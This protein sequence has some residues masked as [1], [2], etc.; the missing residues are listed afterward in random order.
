MGQNECSDVVRMT[1]HLIGRFTWRIFANQL[2][3][4]IIFFYKD[5]LETVFSENEFWIR[6]ECCCFCFVFRKGLDPVVLNIPQLLNVP[7]AQWSNAADF[8]LL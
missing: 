7:D 1:P 4:Q 3:D 5:F 6:S 8:C 2:S